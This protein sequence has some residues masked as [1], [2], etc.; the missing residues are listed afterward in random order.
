AVAYIGIAAITIL[1][2]LAFLISYDGN[3]AYLAE[4]Q[5]AVQPLGAFQGPPPANLVAELPRLDAYHNVLTVADEYRG[6]VPFSM[7]F[8]LYQGRSLGGAALDAYVRELN[9]GLA[10]AIASTF[11]DRMAQLASDPDKLYEYLKIYLMFGSPER[12]VP[13]EVQFVTDR[14]WQLHFANDAATVGRLQ[15]HVA[16]LLADQRRGPPLRLGSDLVERA[17]TALRPASRR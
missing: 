7:R 4:V 3:K 16:A 2:V 17:R 10:P 6:G 13:A 14:E 12:L 11:R 5:K 1:G 15:A 8:G 9:A